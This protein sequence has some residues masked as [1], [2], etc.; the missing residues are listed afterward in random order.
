MNNLSSN[1]L[2]ALAVVCLLGCG[3]P[4]PETPK[5]SGASAL[6][7]ATADKYS[8]MKSYEGSWEWKLTDGGVTKTMAR[9][10]TF[11]S[12][13]FYNL[14]V[15]S[16]EG[17]TVSAI[18][19]GKKGYVLNDQLSEFTTAPDSIP[20]A[21]ESP[22]MISPTLAGTPFLQ[23][24]GSA[25]RVIDERVEPSF[26]PD[27][28]VNGDKCKV[29]K[30]FCKGPFGTTELAISEKT[31]LIVKITCRLEPIRKDLNRIFREEAGIKMVEEFRSQK[32]DF[33][34]S[35]SSFEV[36]IP[37]GVVM[38]PGLAPA[39]ALLPGK[40]APDLEVTTLT[41]K[42]LKISD[43]RGKVLLLDF[44]A[45]WCGPC[46][47]TLPTTAETYRLTSRSD[48]E[49][50]A[51]TDEGPDKIKPF[52]AESKL[53]LPWAT[54]TQDLAK[55]VYRIS[56]L[57]TFIVIDREGKIVNV[58]VGAGNEPAIAQALASCG[59]KPKGS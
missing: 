47:Q 20:D 53:A 59:V 26:L 38:R 43:F 10:F 56:S 36:Q 28:T 4:A 29:V 45:T 6:L 22:L 13:N 49:V 21:T 51:I 2:S 12:P 54:D 1:L 25:A 48:L 27:E 37:K 44:W 46:R 19:D 50:L 58:T 8:K 32:P 16:E 23:F 5:I 24:F 55:R 17:K 31:G 3:S 33:T 15:K 7:T 42:K 39:S 11:K 40:P 41:G 52:A 18:C 57:P 9:S 14:T 35:D 30:F 34:V